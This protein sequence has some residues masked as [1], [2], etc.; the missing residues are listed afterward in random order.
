MIPEGSGYEP[1]VPLSPDG[2]QSHVPLHSSLVARAEVQSCFMQ[3]RVALQT[4]NLLLH[5]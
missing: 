3:G 4:A 1:E 2:A 5:R